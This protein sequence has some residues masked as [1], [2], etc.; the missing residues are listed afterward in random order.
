MCW[1]L[2]ARC[3]CCS[4][5]ML[6]ER[7]GLC[8]TSLPPLPRGSPPTWHTSSI[9]HTASS[10]G[11]LGSPDHRICPAPVWWWRGVIPSDVWWMAALESSYLAAPYCHDDRWYFKR[12]S[13]VFPLRTKHRQPGV[14]IC[15]VLNLR[16]WRMSNQVWLHW[17]LLTMGNKCISQSQFPLGNCIWL[18]KRTAR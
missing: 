5:V 11:V 12:V 8:S 7:D 2:A 13:N 14:F 6:N 1:V 9:K 17:A 16:I 15:L 10:Q 4:V 18:V 3:T